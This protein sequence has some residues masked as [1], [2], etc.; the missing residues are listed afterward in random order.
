MGGDRWLPGRLA[1]GGQELAQVGGGE[2]GR[3]RLEPDAV[4]EQVND[5]G[6]DPRG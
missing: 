4:N 5:G 1:L 2:S 3:H 6:V